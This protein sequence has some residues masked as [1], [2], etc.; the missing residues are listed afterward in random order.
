[1]VICEET[2]SVAIAER[3]LPLNQQRKHSFSLE[4]SYKFIYK[5]AADDATWHR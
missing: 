2:L 3:I 5:M 1:M 4:L